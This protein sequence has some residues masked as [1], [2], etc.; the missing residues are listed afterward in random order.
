M[1]SEKHGEVQ[2]KKEFVWKLSLYVVSSA[3]NSKEACLNLKTL[4]EEY[5]PR[6]YELE[7]VDII[8]SPLKA[9]KDGVNVAPTLIKWDPPPVCRLVGALKERAV[10]L[11]CLGLKEKSGE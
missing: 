5:L 2:P 1:G 8:E 3:P 4:L 6:Q 10:L 7:I 9:I 11:D